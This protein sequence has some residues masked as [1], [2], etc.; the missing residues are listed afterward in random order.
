MA[1][2]LDPDQFEA[3]ALRAQAREDAG[4]RDGALQD[5]HQVLRLK[6]D[7]GYAFLP[8]ATLSWWKGDWPGAQDAFIRAYGFQDDE[9]SLALCAAL[10]AIRQGR[11]GDVSAILAP[12]LSRMPVDSWYREVARFLLERS[13]EGQLLAQI[14]RER[15][16][17]LKARML[18][19]VGVTYLST[20][21]DRAGLVYLTQADGKGAPHRVETALVRI[22]LDRSA[23]EPS[24]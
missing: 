14:D 19:Y 20:G 23:A 8:L 7:Y 2:R 21:M 15:D 9:P 22:E 13:S 17:A 12:A 24:R 18:F 4:D 16:V 5:W 10:C 11:Q 1:I 6:P 3:Y